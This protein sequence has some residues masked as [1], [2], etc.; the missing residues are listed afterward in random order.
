MYLHFVSYLGFWKTKF[1]MEQPYM[2]PSL[3]WQYY[4]LM[5]WRLLESGHQQ[6]WYWLPSRNMPSPASEELTHWGRVT[7]TC[8]SNLTT[9]ASDNGLSPCRCQAIIWTNAGILL[10]GPLWTD[11]NEILIEIPP[12]SFKKMCLKVSSAKWRPFCFSLNE[13]IKIYSQSATCG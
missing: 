9:I 8:V 6:A 1:T 12:F 10:I 5:L 11:F 13:L 4:L 2:L 3:Y 7:H